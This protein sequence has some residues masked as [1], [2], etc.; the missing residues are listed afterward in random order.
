MNEQKA[1]DIMLSS[2]DGGGVISDEVLAL[3]FALAC[4]CLILSGLVW[5]CG[6]LLSEAR[7]HAYKV[8]PGGDLSMTPD[9]IF[10][11][12]AF[13]SDFFKDLAQR[14]ARWREL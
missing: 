9:L 11:N 7:A 13:A 14:T 6:Q 3:G 5:V 8:A 2:S 10:K 1:Y 12:E 4:S